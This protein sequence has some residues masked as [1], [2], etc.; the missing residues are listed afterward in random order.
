MTV[1]SAAWD[2]MYKER[3]AL[4]AAS[5]RERGIA[6]ARFEDFEH[7]RSPSVR[8]LCGHPG[9][10]FLLVSS[11]GN[12][13]LIPWDVNMA[14]A[15]SHA[16]E[17]LPY[18]SFGR[19]PGK[20]TRAA[21]EWLGIPPGSKVELSSSTPYPSYVDHVAAL[22]EWDLVCQE[23]GASAKVLSLRARKDPSELEIYVRAS[24]LTDR[25]MDEVE[26]ALRSGDLAR[27]V[28][29]ALFIERKAL[30]AEAEGLGFD[31]IAAGPGRSFGIHAFPSY[32]AGP[33]ASEGMSIL[34]FGVVV[35]GYTSDVTMSFFKGKLSPEQERRVELVRQAYDLGVAAC[36]PGV[37]AREVAQRVDDFFSRHEVVMPHALGHGIGLESHEYPGINLREENS[38]VLEPGMIVTIEPGLYDPTLGGVRLENDILITELGHR[39]LTH[40]RIV[41]L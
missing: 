16:D 39:V 9:D 22:E 5:L 1:N 25:I 3:R 32:G 20:A 28:D 30:E 23:D 37:P 17:I 40:S 33:F 24:A 7:L 34:D 21:L 35:E 2:T 27:E 8:Y 26:A 13:V 15:M 29:V 14:R 36:G 41:R 18:T 19:N 31:T 4:L 38:A 6:A 10:A 11:T 12:S